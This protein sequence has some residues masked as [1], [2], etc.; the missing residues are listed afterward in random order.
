MT[1]KSSNFSSSGRSKVASTSSWEWWRRWMSSPSAP[2]TWLPP[3]QSNNQK[4]VAPPTCRCRTRFRMIQL[5]A[6]MGCWPLAKLSSS[7]LSSVERGSSGT[8]CTGTSWELTSRRR[9]I[10]SKKTWSRQGS[11]LAR[12]CSSR[13]SGGRSSRARSLSWM[14]SK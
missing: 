5:V 2:A 12:T 3:L 6:R 8:V 13:R 9:R 14:P 10:K 7:R 1:Q 11:H 4:S